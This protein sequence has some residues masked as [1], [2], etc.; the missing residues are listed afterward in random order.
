ML[1]TKELKISELMLF[2]KF[3]NSHE[4]GQRHINTFL[5]NDEELL[6]KNTSYMKKSTEE[7]MKGEGRYFDAIIR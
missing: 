2:K 5:G 7:Q 6:E 1:D 4:R 3:N